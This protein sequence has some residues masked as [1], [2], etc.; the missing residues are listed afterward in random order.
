MP[1]RVNGRIKKM[2]SRYPISFFVSKSDTRLICS[3]QP[4]NAGAKH[5][6]VALSSQSTP[7]D[8]WL[9]PPA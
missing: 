5:D 2:Y 7:Q 3:T 4:R 9:D 6:V 8:L 1:R